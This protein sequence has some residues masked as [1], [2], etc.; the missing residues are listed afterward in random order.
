VLGRWGVLIISCHFPSIGDTAQYALDRRDFLRLVGG[1]ELVSHAEQ[2][3]Q[4]IGRD[5]GHANQHGAV[6]EI[7]VDYVVTIGSGCEQFGAVAEADAPRK[8]TLVRQW[9]F[10]VLCHQ[11]VMLCTGLEEVLLREGSI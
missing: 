7:V 5:A 8:R 1:H 3:A 6:V 4:D 9:Y 11:G 2:V 10:L